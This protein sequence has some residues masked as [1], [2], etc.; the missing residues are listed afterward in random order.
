LRLEEDRYAD[1]GEDEVGDGH[2]GES[3]EEQER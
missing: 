1:L 2:T 3:G